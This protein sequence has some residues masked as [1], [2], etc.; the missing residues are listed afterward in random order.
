MGKS[1]R[2]KKALVQLSSVASTCQAR[3]E[4][5]ERELPNAKC[6]RKC[7]QGVINTILDWVG[8]LHLLPPWGGFNNTTKFYS[9]A[10]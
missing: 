5:T 7:L 8:D 6:H 2:Q 10:S 9:G 3:T 4:T 1:I